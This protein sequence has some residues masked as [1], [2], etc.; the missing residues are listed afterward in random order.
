MLRK[1]GWR[2]DRGCSE[3]TGWLKEK[4]PARHAGSRWCRPGRRENYPGGCTRAA[5]GRPG[6]EGS[7]PISLTSMAHESLD[8]VGGNRSPDD[9]LGHRI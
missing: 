4:L 8:P 6:K 2:P 3:A 7:G 9:E 1:T 5:T